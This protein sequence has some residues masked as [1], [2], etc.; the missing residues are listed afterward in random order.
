MDVVWLQRF[1][2]LFILGLIYDHIININM[3]T[4]DFPYLTTHL[5]RVG[6]SL[7]I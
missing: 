1:L 6:V 7:H 4:V 3:T 2:L 5:K